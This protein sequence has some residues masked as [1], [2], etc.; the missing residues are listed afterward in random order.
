MHTHEF[1]GQKLV[2]SHTGED[3]PHGY[4]GH[5]EDGARVSLTKRTTFRRLGKFDSARD[6]ALYDA[7][8]DMSSDGSGDAEAPTGWFTPVSVDVDVLRD[9]VTSS[10]AWET[11]GFHDMVEARETFDTLIGH[12]IVSG[13]DRGFV[14]VETFE[15]ADALATE[16]DARNDA[17]SAWA[18]ENEDA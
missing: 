10:Y 13:D 3:T 4:F 8:L 16:F 15:S 11:P 18:E 5:A 6:S 14:Y 17:Y 12:F 2:H 1:Q 7:S 9:W